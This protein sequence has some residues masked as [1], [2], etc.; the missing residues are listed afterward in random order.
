MK[1]FCSF[2]Q[3]NRDTWVSTQLSKIPQGSRLLDAGAG[4]Q[5]YRRYCGHLNYVAQDF[6]RYDGAGDSK[7]LHMNK[8]DYPKDQICCDILHIPLPDCSFDAILCTEVLE[9]LPDP[10]DVFREF[11]RLLKPGGRLILTAPFCSLTHFSPYHYYSGF[12]RSFY[13]HHLPRHGFTI[14]ELS[15]NGN[16]F[17]YLGQ[18]I[19][20]LRQASVTYAKRPLGLVSFFF[21]LLV[22]DV[23]RRLNK[24]DTSSHEL[25]CYG[26]HLLAD[27]V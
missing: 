3:D 21:T 12:N 22:L 5:C 13:Q 20:R 11:S 1:L 8:W 17:Q 24:H 6:G 19:C 18:E 7:G 27:K 25:L 9:H 15:P 14:V 4:E 23:L 16:Y 26:Y 10:M 2:N